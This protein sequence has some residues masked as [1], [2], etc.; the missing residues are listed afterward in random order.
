MQTCA[1]AV[2]V[3][4]FCCR[5][6][7]QRLPKGILQTYAGATL[8][9]ADKAL[10]GCRYFRVVRHAMRLFMVAEVCNFPDLVENQKQFPD[11]VRL[12]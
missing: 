11:Q 12:A 8:A 5:D 4:P 3:D 1:Q 2:D 6:I 10:A 9:E 7:T